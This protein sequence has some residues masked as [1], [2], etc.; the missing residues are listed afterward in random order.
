MSE[1]NSA[2]RRVGWGLL[3]GVLVSCLPYVVTKMGSN[4][5]VP[6]F[7]LLWP[8]EFVGM[9]IGGW[10]ARPLT[11]TLLVLTNVA[12]YTTILYVVLT[13]LEDRKQARQNARETKS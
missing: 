6:L 2:I 1:Q 8:G 11:V 10:N 7:V 5:L 3:G 12:L 13:R 4:A 9:A